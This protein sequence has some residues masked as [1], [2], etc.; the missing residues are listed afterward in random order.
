MKNCVGGTQFTCLTFGFLFAFPEITVKDNNP[1]AT[2]LISRWI[3][4]QRK[5]N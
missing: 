3:G 2:N 4:W 5:I 1:I